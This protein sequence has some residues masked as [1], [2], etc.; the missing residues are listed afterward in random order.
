MF[1]SSELN[2]FVFLINGSPM[3][4][5]FGAEQSCTRKPGIIAEQSF[6]DRRRFFEKAAFCNSFIQ[7]NDEKIPRTAHTAADGNYFGVKNI[8]KRHK[9]IRLIIMI[10][11]PR[12]RAFNIPRPCRCNE[13][14]GIVQRFTELITRLFLFFR[15]AERVPC[16]PRCRAK[17][18]NAHATAART[19]FTMHIH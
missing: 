10:A 4:S 6:Y 14:A 3:R 18:F 12:L 11:I 5:C 16:K 17:R 1:S 7:R 13:R 15:K 19:L 8:D 2:S 9:R